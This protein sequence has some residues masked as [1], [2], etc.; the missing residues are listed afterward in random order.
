MY[1]LKCLAGFSEPKQV[2]KM[3]VSKLTWQAIK[4]KKPQGGEGRKAPK[5]T[6]PVPGFLAHP[7]VAFEKMSETCKDSALKI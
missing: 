5:E 1:E 6:V 3:T 2:K 7:A 4:I